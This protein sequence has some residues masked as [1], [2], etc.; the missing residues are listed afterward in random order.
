MAERQWYTAIGGKQEGP[1]SDARLRDLI[2]AGSVRADTLVW[3]DGMSNW[4]K[5]GD[6]PGL[7]PSALRSPPPPPP[8]VASVPGIAASGGSAAT[9]PMSLRIR[10]WPYFGRV[11]LIVIAQISII[12]M[13]WVMTSFYAWFVDNI[14]LPGGQRVTFT[15]KPGDIWYIFILDAL[16]GYLGLIGHGVNLVTIPLTVLFTL[17]IARWFCRN[18][19]WAGQAGPL[20]FTGGYWPWLGWYVLTILGFIT[21]IGWAWAGTAWMRWLCRHVEGS[22]RKLAFTA[23]GW[24][25]LWRS[26]LF[27]LSCL[28]L[29]PIPW[30]LH[31]Y[32]RWLVSQCALV[33]PVAPHNSPA[34]RNDADF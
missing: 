9:G 3:C 19:V 14:E 33:E 30:T 18:L 11:I 21:I 32:T 10:V 17:I 34:E 6:I 20:A 23:S 24:S 12:P 31:W 27:F 15:G 1:F 25:F 13:P 7:V 28:V 2:T 22:A 29:V 26:V 16:C 4:T 8:G 5:A